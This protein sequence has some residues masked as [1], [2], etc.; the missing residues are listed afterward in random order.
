MMTTLKELIRV[1][2][3]H[4][5]PAIQTFSR[6]F[7]NDPLT[8]YMFP[9]E[10]E[11]QDFMQNYF[12]FRVKYGILY[13]EVY[14]TTENFEGLA[15]WIKP[16]N[17]EM[18]MWKMLRAGGMKLFRAMGKETIDRMFE[19]ERYT[20]KIHHETIKE[21]LWHLSPIGVDPEHQGKGYASKLLRAMMKKFDEE[22]VACFL[23]TQ[24]ER[25]VEIYKRYGFTIANKTKIPKTELTHW[26]M[27][28][29]PQSQ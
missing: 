22:K 28:R 2:K 18:T 23:E 29:E 13:G 4:M 19:I 6:A 27:I 1:K 12:R 14:A 17:N 7:N 5:I 15:I 24:V 26:I 11:R 20:S 21:N 9:E 3:K 8:M 16:K 10:K 25:N